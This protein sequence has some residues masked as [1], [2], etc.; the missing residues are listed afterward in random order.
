M[1]EYWEI[2]ELVQ[3]HKSDLDA[4]LLYNGNRNMNYILAFRILASD[5]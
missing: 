1:N 4:I 3:H 5:N 2:F